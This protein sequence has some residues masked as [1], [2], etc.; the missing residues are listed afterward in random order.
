MFKLCE[1]ITQL[2]ET[3]SKHDKEEEHRELSQFRTFHYD[4][5]A[6][7][8]R[9]RDVQT[10]YIHAF[11][12]YVMYSSFLDSY[13]FLLIHFYEFTKKYSVR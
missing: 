11:T 8:K 5:C 1:L 9:L 4:K 13:T 2:N 3:S 10:M 7:M 12:H 6:E